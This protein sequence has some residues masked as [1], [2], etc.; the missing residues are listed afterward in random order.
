MEADAVPFARRCHACQLNNDSHSHSIMHSLFTPWSFRTWTFDQLVLSILGHI[1]I[2]YVIEWYTNWVYAIA[3]KRT[4]AT[5]LA[6]SSRDNIIFIFDIPKRPL[7]DNCTTFLIYMCID[8][9][10][11]MVSIIEVESFLP[12]RERLG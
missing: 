8:C 11:I 5:A 9:L 3:L 1:W 10:M 2:L 4:S 7:F 12:S 6:N